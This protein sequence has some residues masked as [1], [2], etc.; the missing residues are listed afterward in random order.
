MRCVHV[1]LVL[2]T[3]QPPTGPLIIIKAEQRNEKRH[4]LER[5]A[6]SKTVAFG[7]VRCRSSSVHC[8][9]RRRREDKNTG[10]AAA[11][12]CLETAKQSNNRGSIDNQMMNRN[13]MISPR[14]V[15]DGSASG[16]EWS[17]GGFSHRR[18]LFP[19]GD[20]DDD[21]VGSFQYLL[22][23]CCQ[24]GFVDED[25]TATTRRET[26]QKQSDICA[27][28]DKS[29]R[30]SLSSKDV[31]LGDEES[32]DSTAQPPP[33]DSFGRDELT[34]DE[35]GFP[36]NLSDIETQTTTSTFQDR[37]ASTSKRNGL[38]GGVQAGE[39]G[40][41]KA[42][43]SSVHEKSASTANPM[44]R[45]STP[46]KLISNI[47]IEE[48][49]DV[50]DVSEDQI[51]YS[52]EFSGAFGLLERDEV[53]NASGTRAHF[54]QLAKHGD[55]EPT[56]VASL[57]TST[58]S[59][60]YESEMK[61]L[62]AKQKILEDQINAK[63]IERQLAIKE[64]EIGMLKSHRARLYEKIRR[65][66]IERRRSTPE[67]FNQAVGDED[68]KPAEDPALEEYPESDNESECKEANE[69]VKRDVKRRADGY[70]SEQVGTNS[71]SNS[72][73][74]NNAL[75]QADTVDNVSSRC[76]G[77]LSSSKSIAHGDTRKSQT[78][79]VITP[80]AGLAFSAVID[81]SSSASN[82][83]GGASSTSPDDFETDVSAPSKVLESEEGESVEADRKGN[84]DDLT[85]T[86]KKSILDKK[87]LPSRIK[88]PRFLRKSSSKNA[89]KIPLL[90]ES[91]RAA[92]ERH[93]SDEPS[94]SSIEKLVKSMEVDVSP[95]TGE[96]EISSSK[97]MDLFLCK[98]SPIRSSKGGLDPARL[99][100]RSGSGATESLSMTDESNSLHVTGTSTPLSKRSADILPATPPTPTKNGETWNITESFLFGAASP[101]SPSASI[102]GSI[103]LERDNSVSETIE[104]RLDSTSTGEEGVSVSVELKMVGQGIDSSEKESAQNNEL[105]QFPQLPP[106][107]NRKLE[108]DMD[109]IESICRTSFQSRPIGNATSPRTPPPR[110]LSIKDEIEMGKELSSAKLSA[111]SIQSSFLRQSRC[112]VNDGRR[113]NQPT[114]RKDVN[115]SV[116]GGVEIT[117]SNEVN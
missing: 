4:G 34:L 64:R 102:L 51:N 114:K 12:H 79:P 113:K 73:P 36:R 27:G 20:V 53:N 104:C 81:D 99:Q 117:K 46:T 19:G 16:L 82:E 98:L 5:I 88:K 85:T 87:S 35:D 3:L 101:P 29:Q 63:K 32:E 89:D 106:R 8:D 108:Y 37:S 103:P 67:K 45:A 68:R 39:G 59:E 44:S 14:G 72:A 22:S 116:D 90:D 28:P 11:E 48:E 15:S 26:L 43:S 109:G 41:G 96:V 60:L 91:M 33:F 62:Q 52:A 40:D 13:S 93:N 42:K 95:V 115:L 30:T 70:P 111:F 105:P 7:C 2:E 55:D 23:K 80:R 107:V 25:Q 6:Y 71:I 21:S 56:R 84:S 74:A 112:T 92:V 18:N 65:E 49:C 17:S 61:T 47:R 78:I 83:K 77:N 110:K 50:S 100:V 54:K 1:P 24:S 76:R 75:S 38:Q 58:S 9:G 66:K 69:D 94:V 31:D 10:P 57:I 86:A 97:S